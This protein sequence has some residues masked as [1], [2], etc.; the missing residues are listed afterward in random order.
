MPRNRER[1]IFHGKIVNHIKSGSSSN[2]I[3]S[4]RNIARRLST[5]ASDIVSTPMTQQHSGMTLTLET[6]KDQVHGV[7]HT[8]LVNLYQ[9][10]CKDL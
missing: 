3:M 10:K 4:G 1:S 8:S 5:K 6:E 7:K 9:A 2:A